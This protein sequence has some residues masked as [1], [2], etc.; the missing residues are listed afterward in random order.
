MPIARR[1]AVLPAAALIALGAPAAT[2]AAAATTPT[3]TTTVHWY[4]HYQSN[5]GGYLQATGTATGPAG[6][7]VDF[8]RY[9]SGAWHTIAVGHTTS[10]HTFS[11]RTTS[12]YAG[13]L[14][15]RIYV[16][17]SG[18]YK[19]RTG[20]TTT[21]TT[22]L[23][24]TSAA[25][26]VPSGVTW[27]HSAT[28][29]FTGTTFD[30]KRT[31]YLQKLSGTTWKTVTSKSVTA[32]A[33]KTCV[34]GSTARNLCT[35]FSWPA[36]SWGTTSLRAVV[37]ATALSAT[38]TSSSHPVK[39]QLAA[40]A[41]YSGEAFETCT[42]PSTD[43]MNAWWGTSPYRT[44]GIY[45]GGANRGCAQPNLT[46]DWVKS[47]SHTGWKLIPIYFGSQPYCT[48]N[49]NKKVRYSATAAATQGA[50]DGA[51]A[52]TSAASLGLRP[53]SPLYVDVENYDNRDAACSTTVLAYVRAWNQTVHAH[54]YWAGFY[55]SA[56]TGVADMAKAAS[57]TPPTADL[58]DVMWYAEW[59]GTDNTTTSNY[60]S[61]TLWTGHRRGHQ[62]VGRADQTWN[63]V[64]MNIDEDAW[65]APVAVV[66]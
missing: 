8:Q 58:P 11:I 31:V 50:A 29:T 44:V 13:K 36:P 12:T 40:P 3:R 15:L 65:D 30:G 41:L 34:S 23:N 19:S 7:T 57:T 4:L 51:D 27:G 45:M 55:S 21:A 59:N 56:A 9:Y 22:H 53:G 38:G 20:V 64:S 32:S 39:V 48:T 6:R 54:G 24:S 42:A 25:L 14:T 26:R 5:A 35:T 61:P 2:E 18:S 28:L 66:G 33:A 43:A 17:A 16:P 10:T 46:P 63:G 1:I 49:A 60:L 47:V 62:Y 37:G 52:V